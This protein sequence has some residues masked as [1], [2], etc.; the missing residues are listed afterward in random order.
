MTA[1]LDDAAGVE[2][3]G[4]QAPEPD[5]DSLIALKGYG[6]LANGMGAFDWA[7]LPWVVELLG[8]QQIELFIHRLQTIKE[9]KPDKG[10]APES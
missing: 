4:E 10:E 9:H 3:E 5:P 6:L 2:Y 1:L 8:I 7:G